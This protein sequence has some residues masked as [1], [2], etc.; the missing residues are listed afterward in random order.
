[1]KKL[2][3][4]FAALALVGSLAAQKGKKAPAKPAAPVVAAPKAPAMPAAVTAAPAMAGAAKGVG[5]FIEGYG[6]YT[7]ANGTSTAYADGNTT[8]TGTSEAVTYKT[9]SSKGFGGGAAIGYNIVDSLALVGSFDYRSFSTREYST[10]S[11]SGP[12]SLGG[13]AAATWKKTWNNMI[14]GVGLRPSVKALG[15]TVYA[16]GGLAIVLPYT[17][18]LEITSAANTNGAIGLTVKDNWN[19]ALGAYGEVGYNFNIT[20]NLYIGVGM[21]AIVATANNIDKTREATTTYGANAIAG[22]QVNNTNVTTYKESI[23]A[24]D[25]AATTGAG[26]AS[27]TANG[28]FTTNGIT[29]FGARINVGFRF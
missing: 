18:T 10:T 19:L 14:I 2:I 23:S 17:E 25:L 22:G 26:T 3:S 21:K 6:Q 16:G 12:S 8:S 1:M 29:D 15:G 28:T 24:T 7:F 20:D 5:L 27:R 13:G 9:S 11:T 4:V